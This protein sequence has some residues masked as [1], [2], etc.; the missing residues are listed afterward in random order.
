MPL[1]PRGLQFS[2]DGQWLAVPIFDREPTN[3][4]LFFFFDL[5]VPEIVL[6]SQLPFS[7]ES[8]NLDWSADSRWLARLGD[9]FLEFTAPAT[10]DMPYQHY[11]FPGDLSCTSLAWI[12]S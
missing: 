10:I 9:G 12:K 6:Q 3:A 5:R 11:V 2:P 7:M 1:Q 8:Y 4:E